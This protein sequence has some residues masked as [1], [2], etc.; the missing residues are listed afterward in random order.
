[1]GHAAR[2]E[3]SADS[4]MSFHASSP[5]EAIDWMLGDVTSPSVDRAPDRSCSFS[6][7]GLDYTSLL[8]VT[9]QT[10]PPHVRKIAYVFLS[11][12]WSAIS[13]SPHFH[14]KKRYDGK[15]SG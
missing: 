1:M 2:D 12:N 10:Y 6:L 11:P 5:L 8:L 14:C 9:N 15:L 3:F 7:P 13:C 4:G